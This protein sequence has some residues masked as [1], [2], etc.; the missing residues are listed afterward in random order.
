MAVPLLRLD[1]IMAELGIGRTKVHTLI[2]SGE[3][4]VVRIGRAIRVRR[5]DLDAFI[6]AKVQP[7]TYSRDP[8][9]AVIR[10]LGS[11]V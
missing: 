4:P 7:A 11:R 3:L 5:A 1:D 10:S 6:E 9:A 8:R 2:W